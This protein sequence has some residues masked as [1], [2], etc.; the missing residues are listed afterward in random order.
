MNTSSYQQIFS[1]AFFA[2]LI[3]SDRKQECWSSN[4]RSCGH[5]VFM[6]VRVIPQYRIW[7]PSCSPIVNP[8]SL[9][10]AHGKSIFVWLNGRKW[11]PSR[12]EHGTESPEKRC[13]FPESSNTH[14]YSDKR[15]QNKCSLESWRLNEPH[16]LTKHSEQGGVLTSRY[17]CFKPKVWHYGT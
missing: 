11:A 10:L 7:W 5:S 8:S 4:G 3:V 17:G 16:L 6:Y 2:C 13:C 9:T 1:W 15:W 14:I 12:T